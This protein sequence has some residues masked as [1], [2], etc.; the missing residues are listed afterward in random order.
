MTAVSQAAFARL[1]GVDRSHIT[2]LKQ[3]GRLI[4]SDDGLVDVE[5][6]R[7]RILETAGGRDDVALRWARARG[8]EPPQ[9]PPEQ[10]PAPPAWQEDPDAA[11]TTRADAIARKE[12]YLALQAKLDY[13]KAVRAVIPRADVESALDD[14]VAAVRA[15]VENLPHRV[16]AQ[17]VGKDLDTVR[18]LLKQEIGQIMDEMHDSAR[19]RLAELTQE[20]A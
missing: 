16:A 9:G 2:R 7:K 19:K 13:E 11:Q 10:P 5:A 15:G 14:L 18:A 4:L 6:S 12:H 3:D 8:A 20:A 17:L 1:M